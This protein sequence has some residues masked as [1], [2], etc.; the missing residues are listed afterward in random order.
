MLMNGAGWKVLPSASRSP[1]S[2]PKWDQTPTLAAHFGVPNLVLPIW[3]KS[4]Q[5]LIFENQRK[6]GIEPPYRVYSENRRFF[7]RSALKRDPRRGQISSSICGSTFAHH[8]KK[9]AL[10][11]K[12]IW[13]WKR[14]G[15]YG[16]YQCGDVFFSCK[17]PHRKKR[18]FYD[19]IPLTIGSTLKIVPGFSEPWITTLVWIWK[20]KFG[21]QTSADSA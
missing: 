5:N 3:L 1:K 16:E 12:P 6:L 8:R 13:G 11:L 20:K 17:K 2:L 9:N 7:F 21:A 18:L 10:Q 19:Y 14:E 15:V 4:R